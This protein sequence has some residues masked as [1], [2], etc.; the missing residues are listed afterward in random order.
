[1]RV[2]VFGPKETLKKDM[3]LLCSIGTVAFRKKMQFRISNNRNL[4]NRELKISY[5]ARILRSYNRW[6]E[7][8]RSDDFDFENL[9]DEEAYQPQPRH[10]HFKPS[11]PSTPSTVHH[12][13]NLHLYLR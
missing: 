6:D 2:N 11:T 10:S 3:D 12:P 9:P 1:M 7:F 8:G 5:R 4:P 13:K